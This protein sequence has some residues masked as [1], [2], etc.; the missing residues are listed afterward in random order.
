MVD[1]EVALH[2]RVAYNAPTSLWVCR[3]PLLRTVPLYDMREEY[4]SPK[5]KCVPLL[6][7]CPRVA[8]LQRGRALEDQAPS[9]GNQLVVLTVFSFTLASCISSAQIV[10]ESASGGTAL[11]TYIEEQDVLS[12]PGRRDALRL[13][14]E[15]CPAGY[16]ISREGEI[17]RVDQ[18]V[19]R[20]WMGQLSRDGQVTREKRWAIQFS[21]K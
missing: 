5:D 7:G 10:N 12:S 11:Y 19:D 15:K 17:P 16:R 14:E 9:W 4:Y 3:R 21:C 6:H 18:A 13:L 2:F 8:D 1:A 20:A